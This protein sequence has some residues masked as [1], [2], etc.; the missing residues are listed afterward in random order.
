MAVFKRPITWVANKSADAV[1]TATD[2]MFIPGAILK[3]KGNYGRV[4][5]G[6]RT[7]TFGAM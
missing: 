6:E 7:N 3:K 2:G 5:N 1:A 4:G